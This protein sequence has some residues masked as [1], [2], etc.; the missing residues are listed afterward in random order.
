MTGSSFN[1]SH[2]PRSNSFGSTS[3]IDDCS[4]PEMITT[5]SLADCD[6]NDSLS[7]ST[8]SLTLNHRVQSPNSPRSIF[9]NYWSSPTYKKDFDRSSDDDDEEVLERLKTLQMPLVDDMDMDVVVT[10]NGDE[11][12]SSSSSRVPAKIVHAPSLVSTTSIEP[13][14][15]F[16]NGN[17]PSIVCQAHNESP[18]PRRITPRTRRQILPTPPPST[19]VSSSLIM[20]K[21][22]PLLASNPYNMR[23]WS[24]TTSLMMKHHQNR[25]TQSCLRKSRYSCSAIVTSRDAHAR[26]VGRASMHVGLRNDGMRDLRRAAT[27]SQAQA[28]EAVVADDD[29]KKSVSFSSAVS[30]F[31]FAVP[32]EQ[33]RSQ[34]GWSNYFA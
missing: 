6:D 29:L 19:A 31:E 28:Q 18:V 1:M 22:Q 21:R 14:S 2:K 27:T 7:S 5:A 15:S 4:I 8:R 12:F 9:K 13:K 23:Q 11:D 26:S 16:S 34:K 24:S 33:R 17:N 32:K 25:H 10:N 3:S 20:P 30:V